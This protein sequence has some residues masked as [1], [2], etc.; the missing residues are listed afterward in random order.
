MYRA[1]MKALCF[2]VLDLWLSNPATAAVQFEPLEADDGTRLIVVSGEFDF[3]QS[4]DEFKRLALVNPPNFVVFNSP[5]GN[6]IS[7]MAFGRLLRSLGLETFQSKLVECSSACALAFLGGVRRLAMPGS[8]GVH[9]FS[10]A[11][12][13]GLG[14]DEAVADA[15]ELTADILQYL[16][17]MGVE[18]SLLQFALR[19]DSDDMRYLSASEMADLRVTHSG[20]DQNNEPHQTARL[21]EPPPL[22][23]K[24]LPLPR[25]PTPSRGN[26]TQSME[27][28]ASDFVKRVIDAHMKSDGLALHWINSMY[29]ES[30]RYFGRTLSLSEVLND[31]KNYF[32][33]WP[34]RE[35]RVRENTISVKCGSVH[36][37][38]DGI[39][40]WSAHSVPR[41]RKA[42]GS[43][44]FSF[45]V[46]LVGSPRIT[47]E[48]GKVISR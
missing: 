7:A 33:R 20:D 40:D 10:F 3:N 8:I 36:C 26:P 47:Y 12:N 44:T 46:N 31:K 32:R 35:Y 6:V 34:E 13:Y 21:Q 15:Q 25:K 22:P 28:R 19:Y 17:E 45:I 37:T 9:R 18:S 11:A 38:V 2:I 1:L 5:G 24:I 39:Y 48:N 41:N 4:F 16:D 23:R 30:I 42:S 43:A 27:A 14:R 29:A